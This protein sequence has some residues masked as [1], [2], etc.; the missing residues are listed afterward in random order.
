MEVRQGGCG[1]FQVRR[2]PFSIVVCRRLSSV[3][4]RANS[5]KEG[6]RQLPTSE[7]LQ[8]AGGRSCGE[9]AGNLRLMHKTERT[10]T[11]ASH[12]EIDS[13]QNL[14]DDSYL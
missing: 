9:G 11:A 8:V 6:A 10:S 14:D 2:L 1:R 12:L 7:S 5:A 4:H 3:S 13:S